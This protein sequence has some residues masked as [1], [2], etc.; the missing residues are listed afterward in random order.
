MTE[1]TKLGKQIN[2]L[3]NSAMLHKEKGNELLSSWMK[4][5]AEYLKILQAETQRK[6]NQMLDTMPLGCYAEKSKSRKK[7]FTSDWYKYEEANLDN[8]D[9]N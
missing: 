4:E 2:L 6:V 3:T 7:E 9:R 8:W 5:S 1:T